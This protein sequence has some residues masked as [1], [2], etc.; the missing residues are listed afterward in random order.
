MRGIPPKQVSNRNYID[1]KPQFKRDSERKEDGDKSGE[2]EEDKKSD[3]A[4]YKKLITKQQVMEKL[5]K[6]L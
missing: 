4:A 3:Q 5:M 6:K 2:I 1:N